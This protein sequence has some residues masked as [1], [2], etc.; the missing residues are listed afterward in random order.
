MTINPD[1][2]TV[3]VMD[4]DEDVRFIAGIMLNRI[5]MHAVFAESGSE[6]VH[7]YRTSVAEGKRYHAV[8][9]DLN[10]PGKMG[11]EEAVK[12]LKEIDPEVKA[13]VSCGNPYDPAMENPVEH[14]FLGAIPK[15]FLTE[16]IKTL[17]E[18]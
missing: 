13:Y 7:L 16:H 17:L 2:L 14:G 5:G 6:A 15:P 1:Q 3:L 9:L 11:G 18:K 12:L 10:I 8:I 4:D